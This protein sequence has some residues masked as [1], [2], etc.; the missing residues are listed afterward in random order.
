MQIIVNTVKM[1]SN[2]F[3]AYIKFKFCFF[4][5]SGILFPDLRLVESANAEPTDIEGRLNFRWLS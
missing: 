3:Q 1:L 5:L 2:S 4:D